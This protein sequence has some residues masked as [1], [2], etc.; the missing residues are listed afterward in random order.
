MRSLL[1]IV[2]AACDELGLPRPSSVVSSTGQTERLMLSLANREG[3]ES[4]RI[5]GPNDGWPEL[6]KE[7]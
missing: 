3:F 6:R 5:S 1:Q 4:A 7:Y 2:T